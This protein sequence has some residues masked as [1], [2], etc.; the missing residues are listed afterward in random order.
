MSRA[1]N[2]PFQNQVAAR[3]AERLYGATE[4]ISDIAG[5]MGSGPEL[6][7]C[8]QIFFLSRC[9]SVEANAKKAFVKSRN[10]FSRCV[11]YIVRFN[12][13]LSGCVPSVFAPLLKKV[14]VSLCFAYDE[15]DRS[16]LDLYTFIL[17][18]FDDSKFR[19]VVG[20]GP[21]LRKFKKTFCIRFGFAHTTPQLRETSAYNRYR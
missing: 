2:H 7:H 8:A 9:Q 4:L 16:I 11:T 1:P 17:G 5:S 18:W 20:Q 6:G 15:I 13:T 21:N 10:R 12:R 14:W 19:V 3:R